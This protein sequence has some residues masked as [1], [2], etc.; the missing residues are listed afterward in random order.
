MAGFIA[1]PHVVTEHEGGAAAC[2]TR[3]ARGKKSRFKYGVEVQ[4]FDIFSFFT[5]NFV[6]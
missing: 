6:L 1:A 5:C 3:G 4:S 2:P